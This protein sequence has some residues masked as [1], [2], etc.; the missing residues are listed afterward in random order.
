[1]SLVLKS[2]GRSY[3]VPAPCVV[4]IISRLHERK[5]ADLREKEQ[6]GASEE[7]AVTSDSCGSCSKSSQCNAKLAKKKNVRAREKKKES[8]LSRSVIEGDH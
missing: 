5:P 1:M 6:D 2:K 3:N 7:E 4:P 8:R